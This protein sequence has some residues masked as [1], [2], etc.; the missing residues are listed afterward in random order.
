MRQ[1]QPV[2]WTGAERETRRPERG[3]CIRG[4]VFAL[5]PSVAIW[6]IVGAL[7]WWVLP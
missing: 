1:R 4:I 3:S 2:V 7:L 6:I 5:G